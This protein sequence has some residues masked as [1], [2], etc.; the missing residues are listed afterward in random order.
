MRIVL[1]L[2]RKCKSLFVQQ[3]TGSRTERMTHSQ[4]VKGKVSERMTQSVTIVVYRYDVIGGW[5][6]VRQANARAKL[7]MTTSCTAGSQ[8]RISPRVTP[9]HQTSSYEAKDNHLFDTVATL[10]LSLFTVRSHSN[11]C[12]DVRKVVF[13]DEQ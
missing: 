11:H 7:P 13:C 4:S 6:S 1:L 3:E 9:R 2:T 8:T 5:I 10:S 12:K